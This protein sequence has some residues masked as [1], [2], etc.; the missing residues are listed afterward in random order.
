MRPF[1][2]L[3]ACLLIA[4]LASAQTVPRGLYVSKEGG[5]L[6]ILAQKERAVDFRLTALVQE[7]EQKRRCVVEGS[8]HFAAGV[9]VYD[10]RL[11]ACRLSFRLAE[12]E[13]I[14]QLTQQGTCRCRGG[15]PFSGS[16][17]FRR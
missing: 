15:A 3:V 10:D 14:L 13:D 9:A 4:G 11:A 5:E 16:F 1:A 7:G 2:L 17:L 8:I 6:E 12:D